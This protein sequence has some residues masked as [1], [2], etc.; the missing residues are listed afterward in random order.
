MA[1]TLME[2]DTV[3]K[4]QANIEAYFKN[5]DLQ[6]VAEDSVFVNLATGEE[7]KGREAVGNLLHYMY[8]VAFDAK[9]EIKNMIVTEKKAFIEADFKGR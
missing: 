6:Y 3:S 2:R 1:E 9:A 8:H 7:T 5:H 4:T